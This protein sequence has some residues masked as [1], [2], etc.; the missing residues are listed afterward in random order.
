MER[1]KPSLI[2]F[3]LLFF[4]GVSTVIHFSQDVR[5]VDVIGL[6]AGGAACGAALFRF[7]TALMARTKASRSPATG[8]KAQ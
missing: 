6:S 3:G 5:S 8:S 2:A 1:S 4:G 7:I